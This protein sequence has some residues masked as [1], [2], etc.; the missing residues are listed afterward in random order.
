MAHN[1]I[2]EN[3]IIRIIIAFKIIGKIIANAM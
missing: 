2:I 3:D 1:P